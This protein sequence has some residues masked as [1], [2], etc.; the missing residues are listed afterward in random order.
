M[1]EE[2][3]VTD[4]L[5]PK[6]KKHFLFLPPANKPK[7]V[8][9]VIELGDGEVRGIWPGC[10]AWS[11]LPGFISPSFF[12]AAGYTALNI[13]E[14]EVQALMKVLSQDGLSKFAVITMDKVVELLAAHADTCPKHAALKAE[15]MSKDPAKIRDAFEKL[16]KEHTPEELMNILPIDQM[17]QV[18]TSTFGPEVPLPS[19]V[20]ELT[21]IVSGTSM[22][23][24]LKA[25]QQEPTAAEPAEAIETLETLEQTL[26]RMLLN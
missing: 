21:H 4:P 15:V 7:L 1:Q 10:S 14:E 9:V 12:E 24:K 3:E 22:Q 20:E 16:M 17:G 5:D 13:S 11:Y 18:L 2:K 19:E 8:P 6:F 26:E 25:V 23:C